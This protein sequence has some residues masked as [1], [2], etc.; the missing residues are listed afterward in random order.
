[1]SLLEIRETIETTEIQLDAEGF[2][3]IQKQINLKPNQLNSVMKV[4]FFQD[5]LPTYEAASPLYL[6]FIV[7]P[8]PVMF[9]QMDFATSLLYKNRGPMAGSDTVL[10]KAI[11]GPYLGAPPFD[12]PPF[13]QFPNEAVGATPTFSFYTPM[14]Y[15]TI[16]VHGEGS[17][18][19][20]NLA[21][22]VYMAL[23]T[24]KANLTSYGLGVMRERSV[25]QG[26]DL[27]NQGRTIDPARNVGQ[28]FPMWRFGGIRPERMLNGTAGRPDFFLPFNPNESEQMSTIAGLRQYIRLARS[29]SP[30]DEAF[31]VTDVVK[32]GI[33]DWVRFNLS[34]GLVAGPVLPQMPPVRYADNGNTVML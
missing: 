33:P 15:V 30:F 10:F 26:I 13:R 20:K 14:V 7:T 21:F 24:K 16:L 34:R 29:M 27:M 25:A 17:S 18:T 32:G 23:Q 6:E 3:I 28:V 9:S 8:F 22:S 11:V 4:D 2:G 1:M 5:S 19:V 12:Q 31:G